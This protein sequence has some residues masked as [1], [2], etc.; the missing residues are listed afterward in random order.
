MRNC[1]RATAVG[2][3]GYYGY[4]HVLRPWY[5]SQKADSKVAN[6]AW[7]EIVRRCASV[8]VRLD[9]SHRRQWHDKAVTGQ[10]LGGFQ[11][12]VQEGIDMFCPAANK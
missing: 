10:H 4:T 2:V 3:V 12:L 9:R 11:E 7:D 5:Q 6:D 1:G 8:G